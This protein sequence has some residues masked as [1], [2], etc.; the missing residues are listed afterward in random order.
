MRFVL[1]AVSVFVALGLCWW[2]RPA[3]IDGAEPAKPAKEHAAPVVRH[4]SRNSAGADAKALARS[5]AGDPGARRAR[6]SGADGWARAQ[7][8]RRPGAGEGQ[9]R[10][11]AAAI[12]HRARVHGCIRWVEV[13]ARR[14]SRRGGAFA[15]SQPL[16]A[17]PLTVSRVSQ[18]VVQ[19]EKASRLARARANASFVL[20]MFSGRYLWVLITRGPAATASL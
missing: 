16:T 4:T 2:T 1:A 19:S 7:S 20:S 5:S 10:A 12:A 11:V 18:E 3:P 17:V 9:V 15:R 13:R 6:R 8:R 14:L